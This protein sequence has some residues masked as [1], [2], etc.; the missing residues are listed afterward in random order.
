MHCE[1]TEIHLDRLV[2][3]VN[4]VNGIAGSISPVDKTVLW[5][6]VLVRV[7]WGCV[8]L[9]LFTIPCKGNANFHSDIQRTLII[10]N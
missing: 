8:A 7:S 6:I 1:G 4:Y 9:Y 10:S 3:Q 5:F 2:A